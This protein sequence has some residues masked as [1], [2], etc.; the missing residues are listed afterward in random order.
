MGPVRIVEGN[1]V[2]LRMPDPNLHSGAQ[3]RRAKWRGAA[4]L[5]PPALELL[6]TLLAPR[7]NQEFCYFLQMFHILSFF[8]HSFAWAKSIWITKV[9]SIYVGGLS[10]V[11]EVAPEWKPRFRTAHSLIQFHI[12]SGHQCFFEDAHLNIWKSNTWHFLKGLDV[13]IWWRA[14]PFHL[15]GGFQPFQRL[16]ISSKRVGWNRNENRLPRD[17]LDFPLVFNDRN[18][19]D[20]HMWISL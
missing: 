13:S 1:W 6:G 5:V 4:L 2:S 15:Q 8:P 16:I 20:F 7:N 3:E 12:L 17:R 19:D 18:A 10:V 11:G 9:Q 14:G